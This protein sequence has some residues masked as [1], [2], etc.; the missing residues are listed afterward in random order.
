MLTGG[1]K[2]TARFM[3]QDFFDFVPSHT[4]VMLSNYKPQ[5]DANDA[6]L[7]RRVQL[8]PFNVVISPNK[9]D[10]ELADKIKAR[11][12]AGVLHWIVEGARQWQ[13]PRTESARRRARA[14][15]SLPR[16]RG[17]DRALH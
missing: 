16:G 9:Q 2:L 10:R 7:W 14:N 3:R 17:R 12:A 6:A 5:A 13:T 11:E 15:E 8:V 1:D 4:L